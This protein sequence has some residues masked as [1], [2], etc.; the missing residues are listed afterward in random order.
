MRSFLA[1]MFVMA[2]VAL[3]TA[4]CSSMDM[5]WDDSGTSARK[6]AA[7]SSGAAEGRS[8]ASRTG[9]ERRPWVAIAAFEGP[10]HAPIAS[11]GIGPGM[12]EALRSQLARQGA[13]DASLDIALGR[14]V[15]DAAV[16]SESQ[17]QRRLKQIARLHPQADVVVLGVVEKCDHVAHSPDDLSKWGPSRS[18][19]QATVDLKITLVDLRAARL[20]GADEFHGLA[21]AT[22]APTS[23]TYRSIAF[24]SSAFWQTPL[25]LATRDALA[26][27]SEWIARNAPAPEQMSASGDIRVV[28]Q[29][30]SRRI[31]LS[32]NALDAAVEGDVLY[33]CVWSNDGVNLRTVNDPLTSR[34]LMARMEGRRLAASPTA[35]LLGEKPAGID[36]R[37]AMLCRQRPEDASVLMANTAARNR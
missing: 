20:V 19:M 7:D 5:P 28:D 24:G 34:P 22:D 10:S 12:S 32:G 9:R 15:A 23:T 31:R 35:W 36:L 14:E 29:I 2:A 11:S 26:D 37:G 16:L 33:V 6:P 25:G 3:A 8:L 18:R 30:D 17:R 27:A 21:W 13:V 4:G 1:R